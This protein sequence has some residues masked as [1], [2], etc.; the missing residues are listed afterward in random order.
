MPDA[1][2]AHVALTVLLLIKFVRPSRRAKVVR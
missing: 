2:R 1:R